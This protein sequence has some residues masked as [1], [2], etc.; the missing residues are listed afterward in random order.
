MTLARD[1]TLVVLAAGMGSRYGGLKQLDAVGQHGETVLDYAVFDALRA[2]FDRVV[3]V[4]RR[5]FEAAFREF[6][7]RGIG[8]H[9]DVA[10]AFQAIDELPRP[11]AVVVERQKPWGTAHAVWSARRRLDRPFAVVNADDF[12]GR[13]AYE[14]V[15]G[16]LR[17]PSTDAK[18]RA[19]LIGFVLANTLSPHGGVSRG[20]CRQDELGQLVSIEELTHICQTAEGPTN[21]A[22][23]QPPRRLRGDEQVSMNMWGFFPEVVG[24][25]EQR[26]EQFLATLPPDRAAKGE[27][28]LPAC[29]GELVAA[30]RL[31]VDILPTTG[32]WFGVTYPEDKPAVQAAL[33][34]LIDSGAYPTDLWA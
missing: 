10:Y 11:P 19:A 6:V 31:T 32:R 22:P 27:C 17:T 29:I 16:F 5:E 26:L 3:F 20:V 33:R 13:D 24:E 23:G 9:I 15:A 4:I 18:N 25:L 34:E 30:D 7:E 14:R 8:R 28:Y 12:Y 21:L 2:G 1:P